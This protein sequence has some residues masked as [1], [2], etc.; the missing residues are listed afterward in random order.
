MAKRM[1]VQEV[2]DEIVADQDSG[3]SCDFFITNSS[4]LRGQHWCNKKPKEGKTACLQGYFIHP[5]NP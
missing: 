2:L 1:T 4:A 3:E 5:K